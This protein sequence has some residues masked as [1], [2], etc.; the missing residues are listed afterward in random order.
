MIEDGRTNIAN[1][2][3]FYKQAL[4]ISIELI[5]SDFFPELFNANSVQNIVKSFESSENNSRIIYMKFHQRMIS[6]HII[7]KKRID[8][9]EFEARNIFLSLL[10]GW[11]YIM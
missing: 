9:T 8:K 2:E 10:S 4:I 7:C 6:A 11:M 1:V 5:T 3:L